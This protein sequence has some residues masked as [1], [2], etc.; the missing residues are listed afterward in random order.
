M[1]QF[2]SFSYFPFIGLPQSPICQEK[3]SN[4][5]KIQYS[6]KQR[7]PGPSPQTTHRAAQSGKSKMAETEYTWKKQIGSE[8]QKFK[9]EQKFR[10]EQTNTCFWLKTNTH[11]RSDGW[12]KSK[13]QIYKAHPHGI[14]TP[15][16]SVQGQQFN[17]VSYSDAFSTNCL[18][19]VNV[20]ELADIFFFCFLTS[21]IS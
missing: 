14:W 19:E 4:R 3:K 18:G 9:N 1:C 6:C 17:R 10:Q 8:V 15:I 5:N 12:N 11:G 21:T 16:C 2:S 13:G 7:L 20:W